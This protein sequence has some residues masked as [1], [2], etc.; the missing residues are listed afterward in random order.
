MKIK[1]SIKTFLEQ[2]KKITLQT[3][4][5]KSLLQGRFLRI[6]A[7]GEEIHISTKIS[8]T[9]IPGKI[10]IEGVCFVDLTRFKMIMAS[11]LK[12]N[13]EIEIE[14]SIDNFRVGSTSGGKGVWSLS[15]FADPNTAPEELN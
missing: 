6:R 14:G 8:G 4:I 10:E 3:G 5:K 7:V 12:T 2:L 11:Y 13:P 9:T 1:V 15:Y